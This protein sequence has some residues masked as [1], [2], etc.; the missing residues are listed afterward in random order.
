MK[1]W[2]S[3]CARISSTAV[4]WRPRFGFAWIRGRHG[5]R[6]AKG[7]RDV[8]QLHG[9]GDDSASLGSEVI[10]HHFKLCLVNGQH[11]FQCWCTVPTVSA[12]TDVQ[13]TG[14]LQALHVQIR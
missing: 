1:P 8:P 12:H 11:T 6:Q 14:A 13:C 5:G 7:V 2:R 3:C 4:W 10:E 9:S